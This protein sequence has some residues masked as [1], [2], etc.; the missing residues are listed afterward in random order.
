MARR[1]RRTIARRRRHDEA[2]ALLRTRVDQ[3]ERALEALQDSVYKDVV[4]QD[5]RL[6]ELTRRLD[7]P[8]LVR[9]ISDD[10]RRR[11]L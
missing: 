11:G 8:N 5:E 4:R 9:A 6:D 7:P 2:D 3:L 1:M 10:A